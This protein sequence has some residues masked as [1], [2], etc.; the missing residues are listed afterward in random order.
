MIQNDTEFNNLK[1]HLHIED[2]KNKYKHNQELRLKLYK[3]GL[4]QSSQAQTHDI[5]EFIEEVPY[6]KGKVRNLHNIIKNYNQYNRNDLVGLKISDKLS[7]FDRYLCD[8]PMKGLVLNSIS[9]W[10]FEQTNHLVPNHLVYDKYNYVNIA[11]KCKTFPI[12]FVVRSY[13][14][15]STQTSIWQNYNNKCNKRNKCD[16]MIFCGHEIRTGYK[17]ND[18]LDKII[19]TPTTKSNIHDRPISKSEIISEGIMTQYEWDICA[20]YAH[21]LFSFGQ[22]ICEKKGLIL[23]DTKYEFGRGPDGIIRVVDEIHTPDSSR[24]W[25]KHNYDTRH[26]AGLEPD[27]IDKE[28]IRKWVKETYKN[29]YEE[30]LDIQIPDELISE[31]SSRYFM[32]HELITGSELIPL[33]PI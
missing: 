31:L 24:Y 7:G 2:T 5:S 12:E 32:L 3:Y 13:M 17:K 16:G 11:L 19:I 25:L 18:K 23:V 1:T 20:T 4:S 15:G 27:Y 22:R 9:S 10:W 26:S 29:P 33:S 21:A 30:G 6:Y 28:F 14:T 8:I